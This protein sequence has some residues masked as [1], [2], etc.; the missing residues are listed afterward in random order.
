MKFL[1]FSLLLGIIAMY[2]EDKSAAT[3]TSA[4]AAEPKQFVIVLR[5]VPRLHDTKAWTKADLDAV[6]DHFKRL[7]AGTETGQVL[8]AGRTNEP[9]EKT[10][11]LIVFTAPDE[12]AARAFM[13]ADPCV[14]AGVMTAELHP[15]TVALRA[16]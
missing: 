12:A 1:T 3:A 2:A 9:G 11:G 15:Y 8:L 6:G 14:V 7:K 13:A 16:H 10:F 4:P 5:L